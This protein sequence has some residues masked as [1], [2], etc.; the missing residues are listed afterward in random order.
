M[1]L[2]KGMGFLVITFTFM[3]CIL[4]VLVFAQ[5][6]AADDL[7]IL[8]EDLA[9]ISE[10]LDKV[11]TKSILDRVT[12]GG[13]FRTRLDYFKYEDTIASG[14]ESDAEV[15]EIWSNRLRLNLKAEVT[16]DLIFHGRLAY[17]KLWGT[18]NFDTPALDLS[19]PSIPDSEGNVHV[20]RAYVDYFLPGTPVSIT[21]GRLPTSEGPPNEF[22]DNTTR[23][24]T[25]PRL[26][27][28][29]EADGIISTFVLDDWTG[30]TNSIFRTA[31]VK[32]NQNYLK[33]EGVDFDDSRVLTVLF[34]TQVPHVDRSIL[35]F[36]FAKIFDLPTVESYADLLEAYGLDPDV[37]T[38]SPKDSGHGEVYS[39]HL[40]FNDIMRSGLDCFGSFALISVHP[41]SRGAVFGGFYEAGM[42]GDSLNGNLGDDHD[43]YSIYLGLRYSLPNAGLKYPKVGFEYNHGSKYWMGLFSSGGGDLVNKLSVAGDAYEIYYIQPIIEK[44]MFCRL[45]G[46]YMDW[47]YDNSIPFGTV[48]DSDMTTTNIYLLMDV[49]F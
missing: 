4:G 3:F 38:S 26:F 41:R 31:Y 16:E 48:Q 47:D 22:R 33:D 45:G 7:K 30:L 27:V 13:E 24:A 11:E 1:I 19:Y 37:I 43:G 29:G 35:W 14:K 46:V 28:D 20:E 5:E 42:F 17:F 49:R 9:E 2:R 8:T 25:Y 40:Q 36:S 15:P 18:T 32:L 23:K 10:R 39:F 12:I 34:E 21:I 6:T 44:R